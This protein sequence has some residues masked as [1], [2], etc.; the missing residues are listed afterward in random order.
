MPCF[1]LD[2]RK[3][4]NYAA[5]LHV[6]CQRGQTIANCFVL[7]TKR[8]V[9]SPDVIALKLR[10]KTSRSICQRGVLECVPL[11]SVC[12]L[13]FHV[14][15]PLT[16]WWLCVFLYFESFS[17]RISIDNF[18]KGGETVLWGWTSWQWKPHLYSKKKILEC[19]ALACVRMSVDYRKTF[20]YDVQFMHRF[21]KSISGVLMLQKHK[22]NAVRF[23]C[24]SSY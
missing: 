24:G 5:P 10:P 16:F 15:T 2:A 12:Q 1:R 23:R 20:N 6:D 21:S 18:R 8:H 14:S 3:S 7:K 17:R 19:D 22:N 11:P 4:S 9:Q 13:L